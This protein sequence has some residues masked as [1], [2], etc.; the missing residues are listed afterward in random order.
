MNG[1][2]EKFIIRL[3][4]IILRVLRSPVMCFMDFYQARDISGFPGRQE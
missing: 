1:V 2:A 4:I 3:L